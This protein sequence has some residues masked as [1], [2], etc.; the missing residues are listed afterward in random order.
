MLLF[1]F[2]Q[3]QELQ[4]YEVPQ[5]IT[6]IDGN[7]DD[8]QICVGYKNQF[9]LINE[10]NGDT[11]Q[12]YNVETSKVRVVILWILCGVCFITTQR[13]TLFF[14]SS[15]SPSVPISWQ[16]SPLDELVQNFVWSLILMGQ[17]I[18]VLVAVWNQLFL[19]KWS[20]PISKTHAT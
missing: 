12:L 1:F 2:S 8:N 13:V 16:L 3:F 10:K 11:L 4:T 20:I 18:T 5:L 17:I 6:L 15:V 9:D 19:Y 7:R 14:W